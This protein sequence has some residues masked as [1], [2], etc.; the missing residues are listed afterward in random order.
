MYMCI[1]R[2]VWVYMYIDIY[3]LVGVY[4]YSGIESF[5]LRRRDRASH[6]LAGIMLCSTMRRIGLRVR[7]EGPVAGGPACS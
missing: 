4:I 6:S 3:I 7:A 1:Y 2:F 5:A